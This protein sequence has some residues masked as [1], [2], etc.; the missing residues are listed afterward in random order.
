MTLSADLIRWSLVPLLL[1]TAL[2]HS[3][4]TSVCWQTQISW[5]N[6]CKQ[7]LNVQQQ[8]LWNRFLTGEGQGKKQ[9]KTMAYFVFL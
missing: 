3:K 4:R 2:S 6:P 7:A 8:T 1:V 5:S 9:V